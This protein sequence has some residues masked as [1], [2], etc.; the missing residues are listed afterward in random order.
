MGA[1]GFDY[2][3]KGYSI[4]EVYDELVREAIS[5]YGDRSYNGTISTCDLGRC[6][7]KFD[8]YTKTNEKAAYKHVEERDG[9]RKW[10]ADYVQLGVCEYHVLTVKK[11]AV[12]AKAPAYKLKFVVEAEDPNCYNHYLQIKAFATKKEADT[13][14]LERTLSKKVRHRVV[15][16]YVLESGNPALTETYIEKKIYK[17]RPKLKPS[18]NRMIVPVYM[19]LV[20]GLASC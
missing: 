5:E 15:K 20:Y 7:L 3:V 18:P 1:C 4:Q 17:S 8:N 2:L 11:Q 12:S 14:A 16:E 6:T 13:F 19:Y 9:G 10:Y